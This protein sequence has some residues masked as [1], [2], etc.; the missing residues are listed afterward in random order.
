MKTLEAPL[1]KPDSIPSTAQWLAGEGCGS[2]FHIERRDDFLVVSRYSPS[3]KIE[4]AGKFLQ[5]KGIPFIET[6]LFEFTYLS[7]CS[8]VCILQHKQKLHFQLINKI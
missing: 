2:W 7:H 5:T 4:C 1:I 8:E 6:E 3:G